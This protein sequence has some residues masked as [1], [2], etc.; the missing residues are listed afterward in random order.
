MINGILIEGLAAALPA[1]VKPDTKCF[2]ASTC[3]ACG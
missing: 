2:N 1:V 3:G